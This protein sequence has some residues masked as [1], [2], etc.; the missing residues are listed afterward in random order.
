QLEPEQMAM[1]DRAF[2]LTHSGNSEIAFQWLSM[3][4]SNRYE[5][6]FPRLEEFLTTVGRRKFLKPLYEEMV[7]TKEGKERARQIYAKARPT[8][9]PMA[10]A[11][12]DAVLAKA[13]KQNNHESTK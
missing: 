7:K 5:P 3:A 2:N 6:A 11:T 10:A 9:H 12:I 8:Y 13:T 4:I 1:L